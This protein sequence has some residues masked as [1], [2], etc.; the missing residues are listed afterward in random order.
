MDTGDQYFPDSKL[1]SDDKDT[2]ASSPFFTNTPSGAIPSAPTYVTSATG[3]YGFIDVRFYDES[4]NEQYFYLE[5]QQVDDSN[6][7]LKPWYHLNTSFFR[8][9]SV[10]GTGTL[11]SKSDTSWGILANQS[12]TTQYHATVF[13][14]GSGGNSSPG[15]ASP[16]WLWQT[17]PTEPASPTDVTVTYEQGGGQQICF[18]DNANNEKGFLI[19]QWENDE[20]SSVWGYFT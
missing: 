4:D 7:D 18:Q 5:F 17:A 14:Q 13:A 2:L 10:S 9:S 1:T 15:D 6:T 8:L 3:T 20:S 16:Y 12:S 11:V 19:K